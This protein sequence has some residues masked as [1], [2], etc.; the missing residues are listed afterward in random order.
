MPTIKSKTN[1]LLRARQL[2]RL[3]ARNT[4]ASPLSTS[5]LS[6]AQALQPDTTKLS[7]D[8]VDVPTEWVNKT[9]LASTVAAFKRSAPGL[10]KAIQRE[11]ER[12]EQAMEYLGDLELTKEEEERLKSVV[13]ERLEEEEEEGEDDTLD[14]DLVSVPASVPA[15]AP[16]SMPIPAPKVQVTTTASLPQQP[17]PQ[18]QSTQ[19]PKPATLEPIAETPKQGSD[20][21]IPHSYGLLP[22]VPVQVE[23]APVAAVQQ[24][25]PPQNI[26]VETFVAPQQQHVPT[27]QPRQQTFAARGG[28]NVN[29]PH[30]AHAVL[31]Q[32]SAPVGYVRPYVSDAEEP[33]YPGQTSRVEAPHQD[34]FTFTNPAPTAPVAPGPSRHV[35]WQSPLP[36]HSRVPSI[37]Q[38]RQTQ[39]QGQYTQPAP[40]QPHQPPTTTSAWPNVPPPTLS[41]S[42]YANTAPQEEERDSDYARTFQQAQQRLNNL[43]QTVRQRNTASNNHQVQVPVERGADEMDHRSASFWQAWAQAR[44]RRHRRGG[45]YR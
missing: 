3:H 10:L 28:F 15:S 35:T 22:E 45:Y 18:E 20:G 5:V 43:I 9:S 31:V 21:S 36:Y 23:Q 11:G 2:Q 19:T 12:V 6:L 30:P 44:E 34:A 38:C 37:P 25:M 42:R 27:P 13:A 40:I 1:T 14:E 4:L 32:Q 8:E 17:K 41:T 26:Q 39:A 7:D 24:S 29:S 33:H 16:V